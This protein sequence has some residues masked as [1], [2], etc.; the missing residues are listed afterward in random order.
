MRSF[1]VI[2]AVMVLAACGAR[3]PAAPPK[4][5]SPPAQEALT[6]AGPAATVP[7]DADQNL[8]WAASV[9]RVDA[10]A[11]QG[12][13]TV[14]LFG[15]GGGD[16]AMNGLQTYIAFFQSPADGWAVFQVGDV[17]DYRVL[18][19]AEGRVDLELTESHLDEAS[20]QIGS[21]TRRVIVGWAPPVDG[22][23]PP[24]VTVTPAR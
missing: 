8:Q 19:E 16:P 13:R 22:S 10:L 7:P 18:S 3:Q 5:A 11:R 1:A 20:G 14:K 2:P 23:P 12:D 24:S 21:R 6:A 9:I 15:Q 4:A 17:L